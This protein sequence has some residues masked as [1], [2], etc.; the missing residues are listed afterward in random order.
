MNADN[1]LSKV[2]AVWHSMV[3]MPLFL[4]V[5]GFLLAGFAVHVARFCFLGVNHYGLPRYPEAW[6]FWVF[7]VA[8]L[9]LGYW[10]GTRFIFYYLALLPLLYSI[11]VAGVLAVGNLTLH[12]FDFLAF[13]CFLGVLRKD[14]W[15]GFR[16]DWGSLVVGCFGCVVFIGTVYSLFHPSFANSIS[17]VFSVFG[18][19]GDY[20]E[21]NG[22]WMGHHMLVG[23]LL[24]L[25][26][27]NAPAAKA[28]LSLAIRTQFFVFL[29][30]LLAWFV[31]LI[32]SGFSFGE[33]QGF[34][35]IPN[36]PKHDL[37]GWLVL[38]FGF[39][40][41]M[42]LTG[43]D[44]NTKVPNALKNLLLAFCAVILIYLS[45]ARSAMMAIPLSVLLGVFLTQKKGLYLM[46]VAGLGI[47]VLPALMFLQRMEVPTAASAFA[48]ITS[49]TALT[50]D[51]SFFE[52][53]GIWG[54]ALAI[55]LANPVIG[56]GI[57]SSTSIAPHFNWN[58]FLGTLDW[59]VYADVDATPEL[60]FLTTHNVYNA[61]SDLL[62]IAASTGLVG[63]A[64][65]LTI[66]LA[67]IVSVA[68]RLKDGSGPDRG[69]LAGVLLA[70]C[71]YLVFSQADTRITS[72]LGTCAMWQFFALAAC[73]T[74]SESSAEAVRP[75][76]LWPAALPVLYGLGVFIVLLGNKLPDDRTYGVW[77]WT[78]RD[79]SG[80]FFLAKEAQF[81]IPPFE[82]IE[83]FSFKLPPE[84]EVGESDVVLR[85][86][87]GEPVQL[88]VG[89]EGDVF[90]PIGSQRVRSGWTKVSIT[91][92]P[93]AGRGALGL[94]L[95]VKPYSIMMQKV[96]P[97]GYAGIP[98]LEDPSP[99]YFFLKQ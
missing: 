41:G 95:G 88:T 19:H 75:G 40:F 13:G 35:A 63:L 83:G 96:R 29:F 38:L 74:R 54:N 51:V 30:C 55:F 92:G 61:H 2:A 85:F 33:V 71:G 77:N 89:K 59:R 46:V 94:P 44:G 80:H 36:A 53:I 3:P 60:P 64:L 87:D 12:A 72:L 28:N 84:S 21:F 90:V 76:L 4:S 6:V 68:W 49:L 48:T 67:I 17:V 58:G 70:L 8:C 18:W 37:A 31:Y 1:F 57:G 52:R 93:W 91:S 86:D 47:L 81:L 9:T 11:D 65:Y 43:G 32:V 45:A 99:R 20:N 98:D 78:M 10:L 15:G 39:Y 56:T 79:P 26:C 42:A 16:A 97:E 73:A 25:I 66:F 27:V 69:L 23:C 7:G 34:T 22:A 62:E 14:R 82:E 5:W 50:A 24:Y